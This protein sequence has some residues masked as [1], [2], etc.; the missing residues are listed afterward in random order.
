MAATVREATWTDAEAIGGLVGELGY[1]S[2]TGVRAQLGSWLDV[3]QRRLLIADQAGDVVGCLALT[4]TPRLESEKWWAQVV[5]FVVAE[6]AR[7]RGVG[8]ALLEHAETLSCHAGCDAVIINS[9]R[10]R[11][12]AHA[13]YAQLGYRDRC[14]DHAQFIREPRRREAR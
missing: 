13:F 2:T 3:P 10:R 11:G 6:R 4:M 7:G 14:V 8:R 5:A 9:S 1:P 12:G